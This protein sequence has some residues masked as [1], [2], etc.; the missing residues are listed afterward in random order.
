MGV[1]PGSGRASGPPLRLRL[2]A[3]SGFRRQLL[4][5]AQ[6]QRDSAVGANVDVT[7]VTWAGNELAFAFTTDLCNPLRLGPVLIW[8][9]GKG[10]ASESYVF[11]LIPFL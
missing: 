4:W 6:Q 10:R 3:A 5:R 1:A 11:V 2:L 9:V 8:K 7:D